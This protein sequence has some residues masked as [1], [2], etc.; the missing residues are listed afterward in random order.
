[1][2]CTYASYY[3][4]ETNESLGDCG[5][6]NSTELEYVEAMW[7]EETQIYSEFLGGIIEFTDYSNSTSTSG[8]D[9]YDYS[10]STYDDEVYYEG[11]DYPYPDDYYQDIDYE[12]A[13]MF[14][15]E[16]WGMSKKWK[17]NYFCGGASED[18]E[19]MAIASAFPDEYWGGFTTREECFDWCR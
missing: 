7:D 17:D 10:Y 12:Y 18:P 6:S 3:N 15:P 19:N 1:M 13:Y 11:E 9:S 8:S 4:Y 14:A 5:L 2:C 16:N